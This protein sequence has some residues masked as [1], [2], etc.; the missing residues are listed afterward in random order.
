ML[1]KAYLGVLVIGLL[2]GPTVVFAQEVLSTLFTTQQE[3][4]IIDANR[5]KNDQQE[6][7][8]PQVQTAPS[9]ENTEQKAEE[10]LSFLLSGFTLTQSGQN[11]AWINGKP[12]ENGS[13]LDDG[14]TL[15]IRK[16]KDLN[17][18][19]KTPDGKYHTLTTGK[20]EDIGYY[21]PQIEG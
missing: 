5:Y 2:A 9:V 4:E 10:K 15:I 18:Q 6:T 7:L 14:S 13:K 1:N 16:K 20:T 12:Y 17:V 11:V 3:R 19:I 21:K 8:E